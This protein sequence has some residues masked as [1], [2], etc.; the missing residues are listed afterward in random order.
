M[1]TPQIAFDITRS[2]MRVMELQENISLKPYNTF[3]VAATARFFVEVMT[4]NELT[5]VLDWLHDQ[6]DC[7]LLI[8]GGGE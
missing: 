4:E 6:K 3:G 5:E 7:P 8:L 1:I 2:R